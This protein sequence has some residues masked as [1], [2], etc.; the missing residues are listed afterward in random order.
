MNDDASMIYLKIKLANSKSLARELA[1]NLAKLLL[2]LNWLCV[3]ECLFV[4]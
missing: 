2:A 4:S 1:R 3:I